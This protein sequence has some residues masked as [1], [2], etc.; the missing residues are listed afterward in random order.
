MEV[1]FIKL[2]YK[3]AYFLIL[4]GIKDVGWVTAT[5]DFE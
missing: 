3:A 4:R 5:T 1:R 2:F